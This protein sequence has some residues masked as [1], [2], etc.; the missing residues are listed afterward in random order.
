MNKSSC[1]K[2]KIYCAYIYIYRGGEGWLNEGELYIY[3]YI[4]IYVYIY[5]YIY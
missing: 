1:T 2:T 3:I 5:I 4:Y